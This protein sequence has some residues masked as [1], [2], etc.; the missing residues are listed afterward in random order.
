MIPTLI[1]D[2]DVYL[3]SVIS[4]IISENNILISENKYP[5]CKI[6]ENNIVC[7]VLISASQSLAFTLS[8]ELGS[9]RPT[10]GSSLPVA[11]H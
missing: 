8:A 11:E 10:K 4:S 1:S 6:S 9:W 5:T 3:I 2:R 7:S